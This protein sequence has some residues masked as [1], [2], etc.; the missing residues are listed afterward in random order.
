MTKI[1]RIPK[2]I[3]PTIGPFFDKPIKKPIY[4]VKDEDFFYNY[5]Y[6][7]GSPLITKSKSDKV[8]LIYFKHQAVALCKHLQNKGLKTIVIKAQ[9]NYKKKDTIFKNLNVN[10]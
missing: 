3:T 2:T 8:A 10:K 5:F 7:M 6:C 4:Q 1:K 9:N